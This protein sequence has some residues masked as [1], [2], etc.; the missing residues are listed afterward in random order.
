MAKSKTAL[1]G[2][3]LGGS[4]IYSVAFDSDFHPI[5]EDKIDTEAKEGYS[6]VIARLKDQ[7]ARL[8]SGLVEKG[9][10][11]HAIGLGVPGVVSS[12]SDMVKIAPNLRWENVRPLADL[13]LLIRKD[14]KVRLVNDVNAGL[15]GELTVVT[16]Q[17]RIVVAYFCGTGIG[18]ALALDGKLVLGRDGGAGEVGHM[19]VQEGGRLCGCGREGCLEAYA[20]KWALNRRI[21]RALKIG[22]K[23]A[24][25]DIIKYNLKKTPI[26]SSSLKK[27]YEMQDRFT[28]VL[29]NEYYSK[30]LALGISQSVNL[31]NPDMVVLGGG[32]I[33]AMGQK[34]LPHIMRHLALHSLNSLPTL[35]LAEL[36][37]LAGPLGAARLAAG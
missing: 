7:I 23:T 12:G 33:E 6:H 31:L 16:P 21:S 30:Y 18:G 27:G 3:D 22:K 11:L 26:K 2:I 13:G 17:P 29:M 20:G 4:N 34:L 10:V 35:R 1:I 9:F 25:R 15:M 32:M 14:L 37:D 5:L 19:V 28:C 8:E 36:G 24:L